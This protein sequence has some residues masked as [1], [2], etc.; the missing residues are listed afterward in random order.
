MS[1]EIKFFI[2]GFLC[3]QFDIIFSLDPSVFVLHETTSKK[4][5]IFFNNEI[6]QLKSGKIGNELINSLNCLMNK[7]K[8]LNVGI[9]KVTICDTAGEQQTSFTP[10]IQPLIDYDK[11]GVPIFTKLNE[12][13]GLFLN[14]NTAVSASGDCHYVNTP[15]QRGFFVRSSCL[16]KAKKL[17]LLDVVDVYPEYT[18]YFVVIA[19]ELIHLKHFLETILHYCENRPDYIELQKS[20][21]IEALNDEFIGYG[22]A[23]E[24]QSYDDIDQLHPNRRKT[25]GILPESLEK[26][27][28][29]NLCN[30]KGITKL[31]QNVMNL[32]RNLPWPDYEER[33][34]V[35][36]GKEEPYSE[37]SIRVEHQ[38]P[39]RYPYAEV[40]SGFC[41][42]KDVVYAI[43]RDSS[44]L[45]NN[46][47][48]IDNYLCSH[49][50]AYI[51]SG[52]SDS[53]IK[54]NLLPLKVRL[55]LQYDSEIMR[56]KTK[57][58]NKVREYF[59]IPE[60][61]REDI[62]IPMSPSSPLKRFKYEETT[63]DLV[64]THLSEKPKRFATPKKTKEYDS[65]D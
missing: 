50:P 30:T 35:F 61:N 27:E 16:C 28:L 19:H 34:T 11:N 26:N 23:L 64:P 22:L 54:W 25:V 40:N 41:E 49:A 44:T 43:I 3:F 57:T 12:G 31:K 36:G 63:S 21:N 62:L 46:D 24:I 55:A 8:S 58:M 48:A 15:V 10:N 51:V 4:F 20:G 5:E 29:E 42:L 45:L 6:A 7:V 33:R 65:E 39:I 14:I 47:S 60:K 59:L 32:K 53:D 13:G 1:K 18:P 56:G 2:F 38:L 9:T 17:R 52:V 37:L